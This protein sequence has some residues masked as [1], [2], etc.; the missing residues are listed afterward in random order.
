LLNLYKEIAE[1]RTFNLDPLLSDLRKD[2]R[3]ELNLSLIEGN[4]INLDF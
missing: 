4:V 2:L 3:K 1:H